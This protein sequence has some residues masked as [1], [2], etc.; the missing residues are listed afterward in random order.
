MS[1]SYLESLEDNIKIDKDKCTFCGRCVDRCILDNMRMNLSPCRRT[2]PM[3]VNA[4]GYVQLIARGNDQA[5]RDMVREKLPFPRIVCM[6]CDHPCETDCERSKDGGKPVSIRELKRYLFDSPEGKAAPLL[7]KATATGKRIA[8]VGSGPAGLVAAYDLAI[9][10]HTVSLFESGDTLGGMLSGGIPTFRLSEQSVRE[11][12][13]VLPQLGVQMTLNCRIGKDKAL[14]SLMQENDAVILATGLNRAKKLGV[15]GENLAG[16]LPG[17][18]FLQAA[19]TGKA[20]QLS[21][22]VVIVGGGNMAVDAAMVALRQGAQEVV[23]L[24][25]EGEGKL[26]AFAHELDQARSEGVLFRYSCGVAAVLGKDGKVAGLLL[27]RCTAVFDENGRFA[28]R[29]DVTEN[30]LE[31]SLVIVAIGLEQDAS[32]LE[33][34]GLSAA[35][36][37]NADPLTLRCADSSLFVAG[38]FK[39]TNSVIRAMASG[40]EAAESA[41]RYALGEHLR[42]GRAYAGPTV[43]EF[44]IDR[45]RG[46]KRDRVEPASKPFKGK[47][48]YEVRT[49]VFTTVEAK[50]EAVRCHACG[51]PCGK[52]R[53]CWFCLP[54]EVDCPEKAL[55]VNIPYLL[56]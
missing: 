52:N 51:G 9:K 31:A 33:G 29:F 54:C 49:A 27:R 2:C 24:S 12:L 13:A 42:F 16:V 19:R 10:G 4:Q 32:V 28:P 18:P 43:T 36:V 17:V 34:S 8:V 21:G 46:D 25:L 48:D 15:L 50:A 47:G 26:P 11:E 44:P 53:T 20:P 41:S 14:K 7:E 38:D 39:N 40:R 6:V 37:Q 5:A 23:M 30:T 35:D 22:R 55:Y 1:P 3:G 56:R 45:S